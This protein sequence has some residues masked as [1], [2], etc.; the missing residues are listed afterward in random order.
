MRGVPK[1]FAEAATRAAMGPEP[2]HC[3]D[4]GRTLFHW[5]NHCGTE[6]SSNPM[7]PHLRKPGVLYIYHLGDN[8]CQ[9]YTPG[10]PC[11]YRGAE[12]ES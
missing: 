11:G 3:P 9:K 4:C 10:C 5:C 7:M 1:E 12:H 6:C 2:K 8:D